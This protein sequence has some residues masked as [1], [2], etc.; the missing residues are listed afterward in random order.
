MKNLQ[1]VLQGKCADHSR[2]A[3]TTCCPNRRNPGGA[4]SHDGSFDRLVSSQAFLWN[5]E[6]TMLMHFPESGENPVV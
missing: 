6:C 2:R 3:W 4:M 5:G 1:V